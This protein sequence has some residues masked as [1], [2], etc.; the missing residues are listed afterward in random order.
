MNK[1]IYIAPT[2]TTLKVKVEN[3]ICT[4]PASVLLWGDALD[5]GH[6][7]SEDGAHTYNY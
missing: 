5:A 2:T 6:S 1:Q 4:S 7:F 3:L